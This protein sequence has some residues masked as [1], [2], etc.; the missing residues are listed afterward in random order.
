MRVIAVLNQKGGVG[1]TTIAVHLARSYQLSGHEVMLVD[2]DPQGSARDWAAANSV[3]PLT[4]VG[5]DRPTLD[6]DVKRLGC[7]GVVVIDGAPQLKDMAASAVKAADLVVIPVQPSPYDIW[8][9]ADLVDLVKQRIE[10]TDGRF[11]AVFVVSR[12][13]VGTRIGK[14]IF[15]ILGGYGLPV[16]RAT[17]SQRIIY[18]VSATNGETAMDVEPGG[19]AASEVKALADEIQGTLERQG[20]GA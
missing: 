4:V 12:V 20:G 3:Q 16:L 7:G 10:I 5:L 17:I 13:I 19:V 8:A 14:D 1:K 6:R 11:R 9:T 18:A 15:E 2:S